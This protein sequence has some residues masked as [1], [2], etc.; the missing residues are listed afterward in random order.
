MRFRFYPLCPVKIKW[1]RL[2]ILNFCEKLKPFKKWGAVTSNLQF[3]KSI[4]CFY[5]TRVWWQWETENLYSRSPFNN[6]YNLH[7]IFITISGYAYNFNTVAHPSCINAFFLSYGFDHF[8]SAI[9]PPPGKRPRINYILDVLY[10]YIKRMSFES[11][12]ETG[13]RR[14]RTIGIIVII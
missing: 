8:F 3:S 6:R 9:C 12:R 1:I 2:G 5:V 7:N 11:R 10:N 14:E 4:S 13:G